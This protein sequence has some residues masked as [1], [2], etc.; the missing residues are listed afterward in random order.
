VGV[1]VVAL[2]E[3]GANPLGVVR[4]AHHRIEIHYG[5]ECAGGPDAAVHGLPHHFAGFT[6]VGRPFVWRQRAADHLDAARVRPFD[7]LAYTSDE[8]IASRCVISRSMAASGTSDI[9]DT[10][11]HGHPLDAGLAH[12]AAGQAG[13]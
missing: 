6:V 1:Q 2:V 5:V 8:G 7:D 10:L 13:R 9:V 3:I 4:I 12:D 11:H